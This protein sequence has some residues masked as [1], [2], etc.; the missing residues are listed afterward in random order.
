MSLENEPIESLRDTL[1]NASGKTPLADRFRAL[2][3]L[4][5]VA[6]DF[7]AN[8]ENAKKAI[9]Y[10][11]QAFKDDS[12]LLKHEVAYCLGQTH[13]LQAAPI[14][15]DVLSNLNQQCMV[16]HEAAEALG[17]LG[18]LNSLDLLKKY[19]N[20]P[21]ELVE[22][23]QTCELAIDRINWENSTDKKSEI[24]Q[25]SIYES[26]DPAPPIAINSKE[27][28]DKIDKLQNILNDVNEPLFKRY[29]AMFRLRDIGTDDACLA[30]A[31]GFKDDSALFKH[32]IA[33]IFGQI[34]NPVSVPALID[35]VK[36]S[37]EA[38]MVRHEAAE[39]LGAIATDDTLP[40]LKSLLTDTDEVVRDSAVVALDMWEYEN[41]DQIEYA[42]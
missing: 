32:E 14:L 41:S 2:F 30:L 37:D 23:K 39:A 26:V 29:R 33:Y 13:N 1:I 6:S 31:S 9:D 17:A 16:R 4:K 12:E 34:C 19:F 11:S 22:I 10:I 38:P 8:P 40:V 3:Y 20:D 21:N 18:D 5:S 7:E 25:K 27:N 35:I 36:K 42:K 24:L 28:T 15:Q